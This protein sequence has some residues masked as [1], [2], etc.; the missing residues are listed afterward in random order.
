MESQIPATQPSLSPPPAPPAPP[1]TEVSDPIMGPRLPTLAQFVGMIKGLQQEVRLMHVAVNEIRAHQRRHSRG[2]E[3]QL[4]AMRAQL[5]VVP[6]DSSSGS[7]TEV[8]DQNES[9]KR[10]RHDG[11]EAGAGAG[12]RM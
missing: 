2:V 10:A 6:A 7:L 5:P 3:Q 8:V 11:A 4:A 9:P 12:A 1:A